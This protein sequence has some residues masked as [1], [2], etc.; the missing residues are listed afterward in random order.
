MVSAIS[1]STSPSR[2]RRGRRPPKERTPPAATAAKTPWTP[3]LG[4]HTRKMSPSS[5]GKPVRPM[6][7]RAST[8]G[9]VLSLRVEMGRS[10]SH[11]H[12]RHQTA[13]TV[14]AQR[15]QLTPRCPRS[16]THSAPRSTTAKPSSTARSSNS[17]PTVR[18]NSR[19][20]TAAPGS[21]VIN[22]DHWTERWPD[23]P[24]IRTFDEPRAVKVD[25]GRALPLGRGEHR[26][27]IM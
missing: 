12:H 24:V 26:A 19:R 21:T 14:V 5:T 11:R 1:V 3:R 15:Q 7:A 16:S 4:G 17:D 27:L 18:Q 22:T 8:H 2:R 6:L 13:A 20:D 10:Q 23:H 9:G 25:I